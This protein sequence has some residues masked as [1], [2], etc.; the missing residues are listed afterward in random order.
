[1]T[2]KDEIIAVEYL[3][4]Q[5]YPLE[6]AQ[7]IIKVVKNNF[8]CRRSLA[9]ALAEKEDY[10]SNKEIKRTEEKIKHIVIK[11]PMVLT[12][13]DSDL[14]KRENLLINKGFTKEQFKQVEDMLPAIYSK[15]EK[16]R[17]EQ[18]DAHTEL[19]LA[20]NLLTKARHWE[21]SPELLIKRHD[22]LTN[23][24]EID[25]TDKNATDLLYMRS[26]TFEYKFDISKTELLGID[27]VFTK[28]KPKQKKK[29]HKPR[30]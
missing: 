9:I 21:I 18:I 15:T 17:E 22:Y 27:D 23:V 28:D 3:K 25:I 30:T 26:K 8:K 16:E 11:C 19:G 1:M 5:G 13:S 14:T 7:K 29:I 4:R 12:M 20:K 2:E 10:F 6:E 24:K